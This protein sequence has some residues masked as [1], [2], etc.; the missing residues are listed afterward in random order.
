MEDR[1]RHRREAKQV[2]AGLHRAPCDCALGIPALHIRPEGWA[3][4]HTRGV[5]PVH[6]CQRPQPSLL[7]QLLPLITVQTFP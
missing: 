4:S 2:R 7:Q 6:L 1:E 3:A 5:H